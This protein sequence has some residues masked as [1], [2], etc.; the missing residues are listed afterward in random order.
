MRSAQAVLPMGRVECAECGEVA[1]CYVGSGG[2]V[3]S[4]CTKHG[5]RA[6]REAREAGQKVHVR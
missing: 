1:T 2:E 3:K 6:A 5:I 4:L